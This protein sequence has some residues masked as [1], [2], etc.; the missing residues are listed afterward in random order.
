ASASVAVDPD[1]N[2]APNLHVAMAM[3][4][5]RAAITTFL[6]SGALIYGVYGVGG[7]T[8]TVAILMRVRALCKNSSSAER[9][10]SA[11]SHRRR[12][13]RASSN[14]MVR[15]GCRVDLKASRSESSVTAITGATARSTYQSART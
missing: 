1:M 11:T 4:P 5:A 10:R 12:R 8:R 14:F 2:A 15:K 13:R 7:G 9:I 6:V 3:L